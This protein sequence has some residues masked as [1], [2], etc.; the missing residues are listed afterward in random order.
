MSQCPPDRASS[1][2]SW[3]PTVR[4]PLNMDLRSSPPL[5]A[6]L[7]ILSF[8]EPGEE[9]ASCLHCR[10]VPFLINRFTAVPAWTES[11]RRQPQLLL[12][13]QGLR[14]ATEMLH[15]VTATSHSLGRAVR[16]WVESRSS[17][18]PMAPG[19]LEGALGGE[20]S[21]RLN[22]CKDMAKLF[23]SSGLRVRRYGT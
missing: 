3:D 6:S 16:N 1:L 13:K 23:S 4:V 18:S 22:P 17:L 8:R 2:L 5:L 15:G 12:A 7:C 14:H 11:V 19:P 20:K 9:S 21:G 10:Y